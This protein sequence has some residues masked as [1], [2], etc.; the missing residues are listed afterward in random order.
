MQPPAAPGV[1]V[2]TA[3]KDEIGFR[4]AVPCPY[5]IDTISING[6]EF[7]TI[8]VMPMNLWKFSFNESTT[9]SSGRG[10]EHTPSAGDS[11]W[12][13]LP[14]LLLFLFIIAAAG[15]GWFYDSWRND[16]VRLV[17]RSAAAALEQPFFASLEG[18]V[19][20]RNTVLETYRSRQEIVPGSEVTYQAGGPGGD[21]FPLNA[22]EA[23]RV[24]LDVPS[25]AGEGLEDMYGHG[26]QRFRGTIS[27]GHDVPGTEV[28]FRL[29]IDMQTNL[30]VRLELVSEQRN[31]GFD[32][33][34]TAV[35]IITT[36]DIRYFGWR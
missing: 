33:K 8:R 21:A 24:L 25:A 29:W 32:D 34:G 7:H 12:N 27:S 3:C 23:L 6:A 17:S 26:T 5:I 13:V 16:P 14:L 15:A 28:V 10:P 36:L 4:R 18:A 1:C 20:L 22:R 9:Q 35:S 2:E 19:I 30:P 31:A 11:L